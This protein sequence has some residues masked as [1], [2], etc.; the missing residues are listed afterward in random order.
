MWSHGAKIVEENSFQ[1]QCYEEL[2]M[3]YEQYADGTMS[4]DEFTELQTR[5]LEDLEDL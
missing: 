4:I 1:S 5:I 3:L 2:R